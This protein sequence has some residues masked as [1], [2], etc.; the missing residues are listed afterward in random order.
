M[1][2]LSGASI[3]IIAKGSKHSY[4]SIS[5][6]TKGRL[7]FQGYR[8][9]GFLGQIQVLLFQPSV[10]K[11]LQ[12]QYR[13]NSKTTEKQRKLTTGAEMQHFSSLRVFCV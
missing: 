11:S 8:A 3:F 13:L 7:T 9:L 10:E 4:A 2:T 6:N 1:V 12:I 5:S